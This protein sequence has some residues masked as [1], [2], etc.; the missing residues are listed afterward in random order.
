MT[1]VPLSTAERLLQNLHNVSPSHDNGRLCEAGKCLIHVYFQRREEEISNPPL[2]PDA[3]DVRACD[4]SLQLGHYQAWWCR[5]CGAF[6]FNQGEWTSPASTELL[7]AQEIRARA[8]RKLTTERD[9]LTRRVAA[10]EA[11]LQGDDADFW[12]V[13]NAV[14]KEVE[15]RWWTQ[16]PGKGA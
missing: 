1:N 3:I 10:P 15:S 11:A 2:A 8:I 12:H 6:R 16:A 14:L 5:S 13:T 9:T 7:K 4:H